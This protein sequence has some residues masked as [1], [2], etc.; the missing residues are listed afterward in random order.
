MGKYSEAIMAKKAATLVEVP[1]TPFVE[2][3]T[4]TEEVGVK[5]RRIAISQPM[6]GLSKEQVKARKEEAIALINKCGCMF[7][8]TTTSDTP[9]S[10]CNDALWRL[11]ES[12]KIISTCDGVLFLDG[13]HK[14][15]RCSFEF[16]ACTSY[17]IWQYFMSTLE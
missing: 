4:F 1:L 2:E 8:E 12:L 13:Y 15:S 14:N 10:S 9:P 16:N 7:V 6:Q 5:A 3:S 17:G 11:G